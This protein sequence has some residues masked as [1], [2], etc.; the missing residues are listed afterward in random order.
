LDDDIAGADGLNS[1]IVRTF[2]IDYLDQEHLYKVVNANIFPKQSQMQPV[3]HDIYQYFQEVLPGFR[4]SEQRFLSL[5]PLH[6]VILE[7]AP[8]VRLYVHDFALLAFASAAG[9]RIMGRPANSLIA[10]DE[11][12][13]SVE[14][15]LRKITE[16][17]EAF[18][19]YDRL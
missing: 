8:F 5:Y 3:L 6:P 10:L 18:E 12:F 14:K 15:S 9:T 4:W 2:T 19:A 1:S 17:R 11:V 16:L 7:V 13:D